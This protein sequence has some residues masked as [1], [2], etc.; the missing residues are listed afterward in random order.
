MLSVLSVVKG[1]VS[2]STTEDTEHTERFIQG[3]YI[4]TLLRALRALRGE[5]MLYLSALGALCGEKIGEHFYDPRRGIGLH[6]ADLCPRRGGQCVGASVHRVGRKV[7]TRRCRA[8][9]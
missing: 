7:G 3:K 6:A 5:R 8:F 4:I 9:D 1:L 2:I